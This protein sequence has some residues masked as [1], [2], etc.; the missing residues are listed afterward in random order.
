MDTARRN[1]RMTV[2]SLLRDGVAGAGAARAV[3]L[4]P[5]FGGLPDTAHG[6][7]VLGLF[8]ALAG[9]PAAAVRGVYHRRVPLGGPLALRVGRAAAGVSFALGDADGATLVDGVVAP[10]APETRAAPGPPPAGGLSAPASPPSLSGVLPLP[11]SFSCFACGTRNEIGLRARLGFDAQHVTATWSPAPAFAAADGG[12]AVVAL[13]TLLDE[14]AFWLGA[15]ATGEAGMTTELAVTLPAPVPLGPAITVGGARA[16]ARPHADDPRRLRTRVVARLPDGRVAAEG[17]ITF[18]AIRGAARRL[19][20]GM[21][22]MNE[23]DVLR[24]VFPAYVR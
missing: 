14:A 2:E 6:G 20:A 18:V 12:L 15:L 16:E 8:A 24:R 19:A 5:R 23:P 22:A 11:V 21:L 10:A 7:S 3:T 9:A 13:T 17:E 1:Y 4:D